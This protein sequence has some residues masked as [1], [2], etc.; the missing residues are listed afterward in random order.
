MR[1]WFFGIVSPN[2]VL[3]L[4]AGL[5]S[6]A[7]ATAA[8]CQ[9]RRSLATWCFSAGMLTFALESLFGALWHDALL[10]EKAA[11]WGT[12]TLVAKSFLPGFWLCFSLT[13]ARGKSRELPAR[14]RFLILA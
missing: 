6:A 1:I 11:L 2:S 3:A 5:F 4:A 12:L 10:P 8:A 13:Y 9:K 14:S 7:L